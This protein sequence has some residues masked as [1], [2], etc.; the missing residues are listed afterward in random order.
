VDL[1]VLCYH[2]VSDSWPA[3]TSVTA[4]RLEQQ[5]AAFVRRG[6]VGATLTGALTA[7]PAERTLAVTFDDAPR[8]VFR[9]ARPILA[10]LG[11][12]GT[13]FVPTAFPGSGR[14][15]AWAGQE[16]FAGTE[17]E[18]ELECMTWDELGTLAAEGWEVGAHTR[19]HPS[20]PDVASDDELADELR[21][22]RADCEAAL[23]LPCRSLAYPY[24]RCDRRVVEAARDAGYTVA[25]TAPRGAA[26][27]LPLQWPRVGVYR[28]DTVRRL[29]ARVWRRGLPPRSV[30][31]RGV[32][33]VAGA[34]RMVRT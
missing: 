32:G 6:F 22:S 18:G 19:T 12:P 21:G 20:L 11:L 7:P 3:E 2:G 17:H 4:E 29:Q 23:G 8:S 33:L 10:A 31:A 34:A 14:P 13:V 1:V 24:G 28:D 26:P 15:M 27:P 30:T 16:Q 5:L 9:R 25:C